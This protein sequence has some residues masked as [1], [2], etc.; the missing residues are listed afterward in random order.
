MA[1]KNLI[2][3]KLIFK[4]LIFKKYKIKDII[5]LVFN[6]ALSCSDFNNPYQQNYPNK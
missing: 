6:S 3:K 4:K 2:F 1:Q 5:K